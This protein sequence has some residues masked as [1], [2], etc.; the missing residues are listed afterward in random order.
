M[1][2]LP[3]ESP[4]LRP[5]DVHVWSVDLDLPAPEV[6]RIR[7]LL[8][9]DECQRAAR[10]CFERDRRRFVVAR[11][12]LRTLL[13]RYAGVAPERLR[14]AYGP[15]GK[16]I[17]AGFWDERPR[18]NLSHSGGLAAIAIAAGAD[19]GVDVE[20]LRPLPDLERMAERYFSRG[21]NAALRT[22][23]PPDRLEAFFRCWT[24]KEAYLKALGD[25]L[26]RPLDA[27]DV[28]LLPGDEA[29]LLHVR[30]D[31]GEPSRWWLRAFMP[32]VGAVGAIALEGPARRLARWHWPAAEA[33]S[34]PELYSRMSDHP[35][36][37]PLGVQLD[38][39][40]SD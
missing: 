37:V 1:S 15:Y 26:A 36:A 3:T 23:A 13:G 21:E 33:G 10:F 27:F 18:F 12:V 5:D 34:L 31:T 7:R 30:G 8:S 20:C 38:A 39:I 19:V 16:P 17:L 9:P 4:S 35:C 22:L 24:R 6:F 25:G 40:I 29:R 14:F 11:G 28:S 2:V 32:V